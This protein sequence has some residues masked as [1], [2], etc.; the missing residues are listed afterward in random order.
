MMCVLIRDYKFLLP[1]ESHK[2]QST[3]NQ[4]KNNLLENKL[5]FIKK[6]N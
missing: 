1:H 2:N 6:N 4:F 5:D 3:D